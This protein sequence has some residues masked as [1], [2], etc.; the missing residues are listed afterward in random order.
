MGIVLLFFNKDI[1][2]NSVIPNEISEGQGIWLRS[3]EWDE[4]REEQE[5]IEAAGAPNVCLIA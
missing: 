1:S 3:D 4:V 5:Q 2:K